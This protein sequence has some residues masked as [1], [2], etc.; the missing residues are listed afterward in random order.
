MVRAPSVYARCIVIVARFTVPDTSPYVTTSSVPGAEA[1]VISFFYPVPSLGFVPINAYLLWSQEPVL[2]DTGAIIARELFLDAIE[3]LIDLDDLRWIYL[4]H[5]DPDHV[6]CL[7][8]VLAAAPR[9]R[10]ITT[11][12]GLGRLGLYQPISPER[13]F[14][15]NPGQRLSI[16]DRELEAIAPLTFDAPETTPFLDSKTRALFSSDCFGGVVSAPA[17]SAADMS[18]DALRDA[19]ITWT[20]ID[21]PWLRQLDRTVF[22]ASRDKIRELASP[23]VLSSHLPPAVGLLDTLLHH[24]EAARREPPFVGLDQAGLS[25]L[26]ASAGAPPEGEIAS[27]PASP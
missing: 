21:T 27:V 15:L 22:E 1:E 4:T 6:G 2:V 18:A 14:L 13:V 11:F 5:G 17:E 26:L 10:V 7:T 25:A 19:V 24:I 12:I 16:G 3:Q 23:V 20:T 9:A 8:D